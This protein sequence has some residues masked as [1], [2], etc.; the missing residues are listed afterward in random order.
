MNILYL[1]QELILPGA[2]GNGRCW[3][4]AQRWTEMGH[5][6]SFV[7]SLSG[8]PENRNGPGQSAT[9]QHQTL[10]RDGITI[11]TV[12][13]AFNHMMSFPRRVWSFAEFYRKA[14]AVA[15]RL[16]GFDVI[17]AYTAPLSVALLGEKLSRLMNIPFCLEVAD[18]WPDVPIGM[19][20][21]RNPLLIAGLNRRT[22]RVY[23]RASNIF[24]YTEG[25]E[26]QILSHGDYAA[27]THLLHN[28]VDCRHVGFHDRAS[29]PPPVNVLYAGT[30]GKAN[31]L[32]QLIRAIHHIEA[33]GRTDLRFTILGK[34][35]DETE[36]RA[37]ADRLGLKSLTFLPPVGHEEV[38]RLLQ[39]A[40]IGIGCFAPFP[41][42]ESNG[43]TKFFDYLA[44]GL[45]MVINYQ[46]WQAEYLSRWDCGL[47][48]PQGDER[49]FADAIVRLADDPEM[50]QRFARNGRNLAEEKFDRHRIAADYAGYLEAVAQRGH[51]T[52]KR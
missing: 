41:V 20:I 42:L 34:G 2:R 30:L 18:V 4:M 40:D 38:P 49:A 8:T 47:A 17:V 22:N 43:A 32:G 7:S 5:R 27:K 35:N 36:V 11:H 52:A 29:N 33:R 16:S 19:G 48:A 26:A 31:K 1:Q 28:G 6:V 3:F 51:V 12:D 45:P 21:I 13:V 50:R 9:G 10:E 39:Q 37:E 24:P 44:S 25:M 23:D 15:R 46:G 14:L